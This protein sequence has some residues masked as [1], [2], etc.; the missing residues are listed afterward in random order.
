MKVCGYRHRVRRRTDGVDGARAGFV[1]TNDSAWMPARV[2]GGQG[3]LRPVGQATAVV[4][5]NRTANAGGR[6][7]GAARGRPRAVPARGFRGREAGETAGSRLDSPEIRGLC[8]LYAHLVKHFDRSDDGAQE[9]PRRLGKGYSSLSEAKKNTH[10]C[11]AEWCG[12]DDVC[13][14]ISAK[15]SGVPGLRQR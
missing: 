13:Q 10:N 11:G 15:R 12:Q 8:F 3:G 4:K 5:R 14:G 7:P 9:V 6:G 1:N 2:R